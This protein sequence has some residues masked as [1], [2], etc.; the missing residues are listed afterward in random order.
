[1]SDIYV[2]I[3]RYM[4]L[5]T[6]DMEVRSVQ[7]EI[8]KQRLTD[9]EDNLQSVYENIPFSIHSGCLVNCPVYTQHYVP[10]KSYDKHVNICKYKQ[11]GI[12]PGEIRKYERGTELKGQILTPNKLEAE[13]IERVRGKEI[14]SQAYESALQELAGRAM[15]TTENEVG[16][17]AIGT[18]LKSRI[19]LDRGFSALFV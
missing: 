6:A 4:S 13:I 15:S 8:M 2:T 18:N 16:K 5:S 14:G 11:R 1:M 12:A 17:D 3:I 7:L 10:A 19:N 9:C